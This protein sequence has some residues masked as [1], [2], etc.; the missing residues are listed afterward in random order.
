MTT[1]KR[2]RGRPRK[3]TS[4]DN[5]KEITEQFK[6]IGHR[7]YRLRTEILNVG[8]QEDFAKRLGVSRGAVGNWEI[9]AGINFANLELIV[10][11]FGVSLNWLANGLGS[12][13]P[14]LA[15]TVDDRMALLPAEDFE[16]VN[17]D[18]HAMLDRRLGPR[19]ADAPR[20]NKGK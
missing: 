18:V 10:L 5:R 11:D 12:P 16:Q 15:E 19:K 20:K 4:R 1:P 6:K 3:T 14:H 17:A 9:G 8:R 7:I 13:L 2:Q